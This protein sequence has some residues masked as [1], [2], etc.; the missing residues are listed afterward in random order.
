MEKKERKFYNNY[1]PKSKLSER[2]DSEGEHDYKTVVPCRDLL[3]ILDSFEAW[4]AESAIGAT[5][6]KK[7]IDEWDDNHRERVRTDPTPKRVR[8][9]LAN[10]EE[11]GLVVSRKDGSKKLYWKHPDSEIES[12][13]FNRI[14]STIRPYGEYLEKAI[15]DSGL[16]LASVLTYCIGGVLLLIDYFLEAAGGT[17]LTILSSIGARI[18]LAG[19][20]TFVIVNILL[21]IDGVKVVERHNGK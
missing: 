5:K 8:D 12:P 4:S 17:G 19:M 21:Y 15:G 10:L 9:E 11:K 7:E 3:A 6:I 16:V 14:V 1:E 2:L 20:A 13:I 18:M